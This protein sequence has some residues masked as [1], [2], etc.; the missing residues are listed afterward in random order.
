MVK[1]SSIR[2][3]PT[4]TRRSLAMAASHAARI[5]APGWVTLAAVHG[6]LSAKTSISSRLGDAAI[7]RVTTR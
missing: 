5:A 4:G 1:G 7:R 3:T 6:E 2:S